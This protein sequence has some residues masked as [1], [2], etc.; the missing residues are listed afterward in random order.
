MF[1]KV[2][3]NKKRLYRYGWETELV[4]TED[5]TSTSYL[6]G[7]HSSPPTGASNILH[8]PIF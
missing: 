4:L 6:F 2:T 3:S 1:L 7:Y 5:P 8:P